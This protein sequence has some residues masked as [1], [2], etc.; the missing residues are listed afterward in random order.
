[1]Q[2]D[3]SHSYFIPGLYYPVS[4]NDRRGGNPL[5]TV[6][7]LILAPL[8]ATLIQLAISRTREFS[9]DAGAAEI[10]ENPLP[11]ATALQ[12]LEE[13]GRKIPMN[14]NPAMSPL[15]I[16]NP[17]SGEGLQN[18]FRTHPTTEERIQK[19][20]ALANK[21]KQPALVQTAG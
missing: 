18:L 3:Q 16:I 2:P 5:A 12:K 17:L 1:M 20:K 19:L 15:L 7:L 4:R 10:T 6:F 13:V 14:G 11:L 21:S 9:A 8:S